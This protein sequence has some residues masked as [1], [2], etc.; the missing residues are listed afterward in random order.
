MTW[1]ELKNFINKQARQN[2]D[3]LDNEVKLYDYSD[4]EEY[5]ADITELLCDK[6]ESN[7]DQSNWTPYLSINNEEEYNETEVKE[8]GVN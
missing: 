5:S 8:T 6:E 7:N 4:G 3:F 2:K 1:R